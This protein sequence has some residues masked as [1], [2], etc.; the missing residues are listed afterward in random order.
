MVYTFLLSLLADL[1]PFKFL[2]VLGLVVLGLQ[3]VGFPVVSVIA[4]LLAPLL[5]D[6]GLDSL[7]NL[8]GLV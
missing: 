7:L 3:L 2:T 6:L 1:I 5:P 4:D 8:D